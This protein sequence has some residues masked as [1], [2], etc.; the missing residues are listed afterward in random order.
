MAE[1]ALIVAHDRN[2]GIG[3]Q[4]NMPWVGELPAD[5]QHFKNTTT[6]NT[7]IMGRRTYESIGRP[8]PNRNN[9]I[10]SRSIEPGS[11]SG[12]VVL[13]SIETAINILPEKGNAYVMGGEQLYASFLD[14]ATR[15]II[16]YINHEFNCDTFFPELGDEWDILS[17]ES[18]S[19][20]D[21]NQYDY[22]FR[23]YGRR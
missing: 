7:V 10:L 23:T 20:D 21:F 15:A 17:V 9:I 16:T 3:F 12:A 1:I 11:I 22:E 19:T 2:R 4:G 6:G 18:H 14:V 13:P 8:L 5:M